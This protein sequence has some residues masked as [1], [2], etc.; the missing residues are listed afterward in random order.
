MKRSSIHKF[1]SVV[2]DKHCI[3]IF[4]PTLSSSFQEDD[5]FFIKVLLD[6]GGVNSHFSRPSEKHC[7]LKRFCNVQIDNL[8]AFKEC[9][10]FRWLSRKQLTLSNDLYAFPQLLFVD[11]IKIFIPDLRARSI[12]RFLCTMKKKFRRHDFLWG[13]LECAAV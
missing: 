10:I 12:L 6:K 7:T 11:K 13:A 1:S 5:Q 8:K 3:E 2:K 9:P 4:L